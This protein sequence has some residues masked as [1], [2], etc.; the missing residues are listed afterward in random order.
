MAFNF[1]AALSARNSCTNR[2]AM[3]ITSMIPINTVAFMSPVNAEIHARTN[4]NAL[5]GSFAFL[6][7]TKPTVHFL[8]NYFVVTVYV[9]ATTNL[10]I[11]KA[12]YA[13]H[14]RQYSKKITCDISGIL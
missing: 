7:S 10:L 5:N 4:S 8:P 14:I 2:I 11:C 9:E 1:S 3:L 12:F 13:S 6:H